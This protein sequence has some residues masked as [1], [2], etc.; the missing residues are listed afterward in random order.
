MGEHDLGELQRFVRDAVRG[1]VPIG[2]DTPLAAGAEARVA[3]SARMSS[4]ER[5]EVYREQFWLRHLASLDDDFPTLAWVL[6]GHGPFREL[7]TAYLRAWPP[8]TWDLQR[9]G[10]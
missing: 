8:R 9:L 2:G 1:S 5:L 7:A 4:Y 6:G 3:P 10:A